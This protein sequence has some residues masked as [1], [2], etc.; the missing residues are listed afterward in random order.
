M[1]DFDLRAMMFR[2]PAII[3]ALSIHEFAHGYAAYKLGDS[4][5][6][7]DGRLTLNP[8]RHLDPIGMILII[9]VGFG[10]A[11][12]VMVNPYNFKNAK[13]D[14][15]IVSLAGPL[16]NFILG[17]FVMLLF[18]AL[19]IPFPNALTIQSG[20]IAFVGPM[21]IF[22]EFL[23]VLTLLNI[24]LGVFN[25]LPIPPLDGSKLFSIILP[26]HLYFRYINFR[27]GMLIMVALIFSGAL[28]GILFPLLL[29]IFHAYMNVAVWLLGPFM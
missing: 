12:P 29:S 27:Y 15:A 2:I 24:M 23:Q 6:K 18:V 16:S 4:T 5:A 9:L 25:L 1:F 17:F 8:L 10:W 14:M 22:L 20:F 19:T 26:D 21:G 28:A 11:K 13:Q 7:L 3:I